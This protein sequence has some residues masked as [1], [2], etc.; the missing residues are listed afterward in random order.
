MM[1]KAS[2]RI[3]RVRTKPKARCPHLIYRLEAPPPGSRERLRHMLGLWRGPLPAPRSGPTF[4]ASGTESF[5]LSAA[6]M[7]RRWRVKGAPPPQQLPST[8]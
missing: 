2:D 5:F 1:D 8:I 6:A 7:A 3:V 4:C